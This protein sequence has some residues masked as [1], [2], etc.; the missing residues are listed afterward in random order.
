MICV[1]K[2][3]IVVCVCVVVVV[4]AMFAVLNKKR[5]V[6]LVVVVLIALLVFVF[7]LRE[8]NSFDSV[9]SKGVGTKRESSG[10]DVMQVV[11][12]DTVVASLNKIVVDTNAQHQIL[13]HE[14]DILAERQDKI[15]K[16]LEDLT[17]SIHIGGEIG[18][19][20][21]MVS[22]VKETGIIRSDADDDDN[23]NSNN[24]AK[25]SNNNGNG[26]K[27]IRHEDKQLQS[28]R[29]IDE[30]DSS[31]HM[32]SRAEKM[33]KEQKIVNKHICEHMLESDKL[34]VIVA[35]VHNRMDYFKY[36]IDSLKNMRYVE[37]ALL[38]VSQDMFLEELDAILS[39]IDFMC[40]VSVFYPGSLQLHPSSFPGKDPNDCPRDVSRE[41]A[42]RMKCINA[43]TPDQ[44]GHYR[45]AQYTVIKHHWWWK[46]NFVF[47]RMPALKGHS[48]FKVLVE[49]DHVL[50][51]DT[52]HMLLK[53]KGLPAMDRTHLVVLGD[54][55]AQK[56]PFNGRA[57]QSLVWV[58]TKH[59]MG[60]AVTN[61]FFDLL[62][63]CSPDFC[64]F[65]DYN[66]DWTL[67]HLSHKQ[68]FGGSSIN[69]IMFQGARIQHIGV[70]GVHVKSN[71]CSAENAYKQAMML[72]SNSN[73]ELFPTELDVSVG[74]VQ[75]PF[76]IKGNGGWGD[77]RDH[78]LCL[79]F[80]QT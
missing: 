78:N 6:G 76:A 21:G 52:I 10:N 13:Q 64:N 26:N 35:M 33:N 80:S 15:L 18:K 39:Q 71:D 74:R 45:E 67:H 43:E 19:K 22:K 79:K 57:I 42:E 41:D 53:V 5:K 66:W 32:R 3:C 38:V 77:T 37:Y 56:R 34:V 49:D 20:V 46:L 9:G 54:Y 55:D 48:G 61:K 29:D 14:I 73:N 11:S 17:G 68:C 24:N 23:N 8:R 62:H 25:T 69:A 30:P 40:Y 4:V 70:C 72:Y 63:R 50:A 51:P 27:E 7:A 65:D 75:H 1:I 16:K 2:F 47:Q 58:S 59:N 36:F 12:M 44:Y 60:M 28:K 31:E